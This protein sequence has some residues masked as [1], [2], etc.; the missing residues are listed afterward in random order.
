MTSEVAAYPKLKKIKAFLLMK[1]VF[2]KQDEALLI[3]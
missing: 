3:S 2:L 1:K